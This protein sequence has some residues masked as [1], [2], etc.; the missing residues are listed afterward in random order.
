MNR[1]RYIEGCL[2]SA[3]I[4]SSCTLS[5]YHKIPRNGFITHFQKSDHKRMPFDSYWDISDNKDW[6]ERVLGKEN[7]SQAVYIA[8]VTLEYF[9]NMPTEPEKKAQ[10][11]SLKS[12]FDAR[13]AEVMS[14]LAAENEHF[15]LVSAPTADSYRIEIAILSASP[16]SK[17]YNLVSDATGFILRGGGLLTGWLTNKGSISMGA[18]YYAPNGKLV[19]EVGDFEYGQT[20]LVGMAL[21]DFKDFIDY[22]Y[23]RQTIDQW[24]DE[25]AKLFTTPHEDKV[26]KPWFTLNPF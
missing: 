10:I 1:R 2:L 3:C 19:A 18:R 17:L 11:E 22:A 4:L 13:L 5:D 26:S 16:G 23:Q 6:D 14:K 9:D 15:H 8:P 24:V 12:Y 21:V 25:F 20:S 7:K